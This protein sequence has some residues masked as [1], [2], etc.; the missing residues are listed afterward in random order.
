MRFAVD[1]SFIRIAAGLTLLASCNY[2]PSKRR[3]LV[4]L[5]LGLACDE[6]RAVG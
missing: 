4:R 2:F 3:R 5:R 6:R 1:I